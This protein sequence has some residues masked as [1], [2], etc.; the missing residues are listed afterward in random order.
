MKILVFDTETTGLPIGRNP[1]ITDTHKW[2]HIIQFS[3]M[4]YDETSATIIEC[5]NEMICI[6]DDVEI[7]EKSIEIHKLTRDKI[8]D[9]GIPIRNALRKFNNAINKADLLVAHNLEFDKNLILVECL[10]NKIEQKFVVDETHKFEYCTMKNSI[11]LCKLERDGKFGKKYYKYPT[12]SEVYYHLFNIIPHGL[13]N[14]MVDILICLRVFC[15]LYREHDVLTRES[16]SDL[17]W[18]YRINS[19]NSSNSSNK[20]VRDSEQNLNI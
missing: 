16:I 11:E 5:M 19:G 2:P 20:R 8:N 12:L 10:R 18:K 7:S 4:L 3:Y 6:A 9:E 14:S 13:H 17:Y 15:M 1:S